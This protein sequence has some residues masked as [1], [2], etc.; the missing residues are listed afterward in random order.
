MFPDA[1][2]VAIEGLTDGFAT[3]GIT[4]DV[5]SWVP[6]DTATIVVPPLVTVTR[7]GGVARNLIA[8]DAELT[9][10]AWGATVAAAHDLA[11]SAR[12]VLHAMAGTV[13]DGIAV[14]KVTDTAG[15]AN[16]PDPDSGVPRYTFGVSM[17]LRGA[18]ASV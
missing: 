3:L 14:Y 2:W 8:D 13:A 7:S 11:A 12:A 16:L 17:T 10:E 9:V 1:T 4:A 6:R 15:P 5:M 18:V